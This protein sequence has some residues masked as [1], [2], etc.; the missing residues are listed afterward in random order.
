MARKI[1][2]A[3]EHT[4]K[5]KGLSTVTGIGTRASTA[6]QYRATTFGQGTAFPE[7]G[8]VLSRDPFPGIAAS[9]QSRNPYAQVGNN[10]VTY[11]DPGGTIA[12]DAHAARL[13]R[14]RREGPGPIGL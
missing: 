12:V 1:L 10:P 9:P 13:V 11:V 7:V 5:W 2:F 3:V 6:T 4:V 8:Q 14:A